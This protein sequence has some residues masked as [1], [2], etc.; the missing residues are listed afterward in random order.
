MSEA[1]AIRTILALAAVAAGPGAA[2][3][4]SGGEPPPT[5]L[6]VTAYEGEATRACLDDALPPGFCGTFSS[7]GLSVAIGDLDSDGH[8]DV[9]KVRDN[10]VAQLCRGNGQGVFTCQDI[11]TADQQMGHVAL[12]DLSRDGRPDVILGT[13]SATAT[14]KV[15]VCFN[16]DGTLFFCGHLDDLISFSPTDLAVGDINNDGAPDL[17]VTRLDGSSQA[18]LNDGQGGIVVCLGLP[19]GLADTRGV[20]L[21]DLDEDGNLDAVLAVSEIQGGVGG[22]DQVCRG[23]GTGLFSCSDVGELGVAHTGVAVGDVDGNGD[24]DL[25]FAG[26]DV[27]GSVFCPGNGSGSSPTCFPMPSEVLDHGSVA[28]ADLDGDGR[29]EAAFARI[30]PAPP[31]PNYLCR[32]LGYDPGG[33]PQFD[34]LPFD[35]AFTAGRDV[36]LWTPWIFQDGFESGDTSRWSSA[37]R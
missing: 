12:G 15:Q 13:S 32:F 25:V 31:R 35:P 2:P 3:R 24:L 11:F 6:A 36:A 27:I 23:N 10:E 34:C 28:L 30:G 9:V 20:A 16:F 18:C 33:E 17:L 8:R 29:A 14:P 4:A 19:D 1:R 22:Q 7:G 5:Y 37:V 26:E 21:A